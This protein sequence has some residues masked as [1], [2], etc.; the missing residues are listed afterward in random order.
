[1]Y[2]IKFSVIYWIEWLLLFFIIMKNINILLAATTGKYLKYAAVTIESIF[3][4]Q[5]V[6]YHYNVYIFVLWDISNYERIKFEKYNTKNFSV[7]FI[8][9]DEKNFSKYNS[10]KKKQYPYCTRLLLD[11]YLPWV[12]RILYLDSDVIVNWDI[13]ELYNSDLSKNIVWACKDFTNRSYFKKKHLSNYFNSWVLVVDVWRWYKEKIWKEALHL[14]NNS[15]KEFTFPDQDALNY[16][17]DWK[18]KSINPKWNWI[19]IGS[20]SAKGTQYSKTE[21]KSLK[22]CEISHYAWSL[23]RPRSFIC[24]HPKRFLYYKY[25]FKTKYR[26]ISDIF[27][28]IF[29]IITSNF[30]IRFMYKVI[31]FLYFNIFNWKIYLTKKYV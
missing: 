11:Q 24:V 9:I 25:L 7:T 8:K 3:C 29:H 14:L 15:Y 28:F 31:W 17:L 13:T 19:N 16:V 22:K 26:H 6:L 21:F 1:M 4:H 5:N 18:W 30:F 20:F 2:Y 12:D 23:N 10:I 27:N